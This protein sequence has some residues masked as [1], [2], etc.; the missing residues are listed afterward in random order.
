MTASFNE[1][2]RGSGNFGQN[3][4]CAGIRQLRHQG[5]N[6]I[7]GL[8]ETTGLLSELNVPAGGKTV[9]STRT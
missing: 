5:E 6:P 9:T 7:E 3:V 1:R 4:D 2:E 8:L